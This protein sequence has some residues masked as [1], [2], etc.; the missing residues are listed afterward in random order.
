MALD[1][2]TVLEE[3]LAELQ[4]LRDKVEHD[5]DSLTAKVELD[6]TQI[7]KI[8]LYKNAIQERIDALP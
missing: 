5:K 2:R 7:E 1:E 4:D 3:R 6:E 8:D